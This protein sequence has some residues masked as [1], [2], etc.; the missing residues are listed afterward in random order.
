[1]N[2][3]VIKFGYCHLRGHPDTARRTIRVYERVFEVS[4][5]EECLGEVR[6]S[7][8]V[9]ALDQQ[10]EKKKELFWYFY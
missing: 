6:R 2:L 7:E 1:M 3:N 10:R 5:C 9:Q 4:S 8:L